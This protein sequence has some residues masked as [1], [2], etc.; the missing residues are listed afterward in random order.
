MT[1]DDPER[2]PLTK[3]PWSKLRSLSRLLRSVTPSY[4]VIFLNPRLLCGGPY[5]KEIPP[6]LV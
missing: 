4:F 5:G 3:G 6:S 2:E 1:E